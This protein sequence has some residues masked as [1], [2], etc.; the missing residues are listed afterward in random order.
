MD[1]WKH[2]P[3]PSQFVSEIVE[4][5]R[6]GKSVAI[7]LPK[8]S[9]YGLKNAIKTA[10]DEIRI[11]EWTPVTAD[12]PCNPAHFLYQYFVDENFSGSSLTPGILSREERFQGKLIVIDDIPIDSWGI[13]KKFLFDYQDSCR[14]AENQFDQT[15]F[16]ILAEGETAVSPPLEDL[17]FEVLRFDGKVSFADALIY[18]SVNLIKRK[19]PALQQQ[20]AAAVIANISMWDMEIADRLCDEKIEK[21]LNPIQILKEMSAERCW[22]KLG[23]ITIYPWHEGLSGVFNSYSK[24]NTIMLSCSET[25]VELTKRIWSSQVGVLLP[26]IE[27]KRHELLVKYKHHMKLPYETKF[28]VINNL[29]D[30]EIGHIEAQLC[31]NSVNTKIIN[32]VSNLKDMRNALA[33]LETVDASKIARLT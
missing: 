14:G 31:R 33:H 10:M 13:W 15:L 20:L 23:D 3:G 26:Y 30:L 7:C 9:P 1:F 2:L 8:F 12:E 6:E 29:Y 11:L 5:I 17:R 18:S 19:F 21:I 27:E 28:G 24:V 25:S 16:C 22:D 32:M 4:N